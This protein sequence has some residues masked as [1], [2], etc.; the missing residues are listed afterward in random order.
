MPGDD[1]Q[2]FANL[3]SLLAYQWLFPGK[4][5]L[6]MGTEIGQSSEWDANAA[7]EWWLLDQGPYHRGLQHFIRD[8]NRFYLSE[9]ALGD[10][11]YDP[12]GFFWIDCSDSDDSVLS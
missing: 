10:A 3:R 4:Q 11:D 6:M 8:L 9:P 1:W 7:L 12:N 5:L 2:R